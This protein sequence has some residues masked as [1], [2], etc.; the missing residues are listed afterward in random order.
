[1]HI[2]IPSAPLFSCMGAICKESIERSDAQLAT[3]RPRVEPTPTQKEEADIHAAE[4][5]IYAS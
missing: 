2:L 4:D 3:K 1:M 5:A